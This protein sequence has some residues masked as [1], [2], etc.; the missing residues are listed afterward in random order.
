M[1]QRRHAERVVQAWFAR[2][3]DVGSPKR[4]N[5]V[6]L[7]NE[8]VQQSRLR[9][10]TEFPD[11]FAP[12]IADAILLAYKGAAADVQQKLRRVVEVWRSRSVFE[13]P[14]VDAVESR[15]DGRSSS[16]SKG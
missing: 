16:I 12:I 11:A 8:V 6:Y 5:L 1:S 2:L 15:L 4:L 14:I 7:A 9:R 3:R 10:K 13:A